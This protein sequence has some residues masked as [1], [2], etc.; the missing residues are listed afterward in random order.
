MESMNS[1]VDS[2]RL[3]LW[4]PGIVAYDVGLAWQQARAT[5]L[6]AGAAR[7]AL[8]LLE[9]VPVYTFGMRARREHVLVPLE[10]LAARGAGVVET[11]RGGD[12]TFHGPGQLVAYPILD[13]RERGLGPAL[14][15]RMLE[16][17]LIATL[18][19]FDVHAER[20]AG[21]PG[22][23]V[24]ADGALAKIAAVGV[25]VREGVST[26]G[27]ALNVSTDLEWF[28]AIVPCGIADAG[29][30]SMQRVL[31]VAPSMDAVMDEFARVFASVFYVPC[32]EAEGE[33]ATSLEPLAAGGH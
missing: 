11:D 3:D 12:V 28:E 33:S 18:A 30:T 21:R 15:V 31:G 4:R 27:V 14:Y 13:L 24:D 8:G 32:A 25:R 16:A 19:R 17:C 2:G 29:V 20:V 7:E 23:W 26:H 9:H 6:R 5:A 10:V 22:V 1:Q